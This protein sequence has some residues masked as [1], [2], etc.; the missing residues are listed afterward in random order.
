M[1]S[2]YFYKFFLILISGVAYPGMAQV[3]LN[4]ILILS[5]SS[6]KAETGTDKIQSRLKESN[7]KAGTA[8][9][10]LFKADRG[11]YKGDFLMTCMGE[12]KIKDGPF[13]EL[14][15]ILNTP[16]SFTAYKLIGANKFSS[17]PK[18]GILG[19]HYL[20]VKQDK[21]KSFEKFVEEKLNPVLG[22]LLP[23]MQ[24]LYY[25]ASVGQQTGSYI[26][27]FTIE[28]IAARDKYWPEGSE[29]E[30]LKET[31]R[32]LQNLALELSA[33]LED[34]SYLKPESGGAAA[35]FESLDWTDYILLQL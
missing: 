15:D 14:A 18:A 20:K 11:K 5:N 9:Y 13:N 24:M 16:S 7:K 34:G 19:I 3:Q 31:F 8:G 21:T 17:L 12:G 2:E 29:T 35:Y 4:E 28:S 27:I 33:Y 30:K 1:T 32:P 23:D 6:V 22:Q 10:Q 25:K 26:T